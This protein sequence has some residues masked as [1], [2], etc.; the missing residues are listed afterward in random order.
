MLVGLFVFMVFPT[1]LLHIFNAS[2]NMLAIG[3]PA[4]RIISLS[5]LFA[6]YGIISSSMFQALGHGMLS[7]YVSILRQL[8][9]LLPLAYL[10]SRLGE[11]NYVW[12]AFPGAEIASVIVCTIFFRHIYK[13]EI[14]PMKKAGQ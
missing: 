3:I 4:L 13:K 14:L 8:V 12:I 5:F 7:M 6:G 2:E 10:F 11:L 9:V 1:Q